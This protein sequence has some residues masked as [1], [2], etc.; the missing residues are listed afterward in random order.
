MFSR[1][2]FD[3]PVGVGAFVIGLS[4]ISSFFTCSWNIAERD[5]NL[6]QTK[7]LMGVANRTWTNSLQRGHCTCTYKTYGLNV[8]KYGHR[9]VACKGCWLDT[10]LTLCNFYWLKTKIKESSW[11][12]SSSFY[13][14]LYMQTNTFRTRF[15]SLCKRVNCSARA[16]NTNYDDVIRTLGHHT[17]RYECFCATSLLIKVA[18]VDHIIVHSRIKEQNKSSRYR[19]TAIL[20]RPQIKQFTVS[21]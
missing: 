18:N 9:T 20:L 1:C 14:F 7:N 19:A 12:F 11:R 17:Y 21:K 13:H 5:V 2:F 3:F 15:T 8:L 6:Q 16:R 4:Q 10:S